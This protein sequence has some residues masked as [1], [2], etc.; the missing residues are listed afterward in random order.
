MKYFFAYSFFLFAFLSCRKE[1]ALDCFKSNGPEVTEIRDLDPFTKIELNDKIELTVSY[2][3]AFKVEVIAGKHIIKNISTK[4]EDGVLKIENRNTCNFVRGYKRENR[5]NVTMPY[6][7]SLLNNSVAKVEIMDGFEQDSIKVRAESSGD[8]HLNGKFFYVLSHSNGN[9]D[10]YLKGNC[11]KL[12]VYAQGTNFIK[13]E[14]LIVNDY[15]FVE[16]V[17]Q[18]DC[19]VNATQLK[20]LEYVLYSTGN[21]YYKGSPASIN[22]TLDKGSTGKLIRED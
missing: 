9:G 17:T 5:V 20:T 2:G 16:A 7:R 1:N 13:A 19:Y 22:G 3:P 21:I 12:F 18:G 8:I 4:V 11:E 15:L 14:D 6:L 10:M